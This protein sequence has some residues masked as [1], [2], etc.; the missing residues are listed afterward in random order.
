[1]TFDK[2]L[3]VLD[4]FLSNDSDCEVLMTSRGY[5]VMDWEGPKC[6]SAVIKLCK[7]P[8]QLLEKILDTYEQELLLRATRGREN[9]TEQ[10]CARVEAECNILREKC[11]EGET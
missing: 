9:P 8:E 4:D 5:V 10:E 3:E 1:M 11:R 7:T 6:D 2:V